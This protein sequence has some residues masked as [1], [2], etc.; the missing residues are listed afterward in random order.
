MGYD[1]TATLRLQYDK[2]KKNAEDASKVWTKVGNQMTT[3]GRDLTVALSAPIALI[4]KEMYKVGEEFDLAT[5]KLQ[6]LAG[7]GAEGLGRLTEQARKLGS[8]TI[9]TASEIV[10]L[11]LS[12]KRLGQTSDE[13]EQIT[14]TVLRLAQALDTDLADAGEF[15]VQTLNKMDESFLGFFDTASAAEFAAEGFAYAISNSALTID[16]LRASLNYVGSEANAAG[17]SF[18][19]T[20]SILAALADA[21]YTGSRAGTQLR[22]V[23]TELT[24]DG[25]DVSKEFFDIVKSGVSFEEALDAVGVRAAGVFAAL[26]GSSE[27]VKL[28]SEALQNSAGRLQYFADSMDE[29]LFASSKKVES[30]FGELSIAMTETLGPAIIAVNEFLARILRGFAAMPGPLKVAAAIIGG[31]LV[32]LPPLIFLYGSLTKAVAAATKNFTLLG[33]SIKTTFAAGGIA[34]IALTAIA[35]IMGGIKDESEKVNQIL[36]EVKTKINDIAKTG[37]R[38]A[39]VE[40][41]ILERDAAEAR[42]KLLRETEGE[43]TAIY[44]TQRAQ[45]DAIYKNLRDSAIENGNIITIQKEMTTTILPKFTDEQRQQIDNANKLANESYRQL[46]LTRSQTADEEE[47]VAKLNDQLAVNQDIVEAY[48]NRKEATAAEV[49][50]LSSLKD[51]YKRIQGEITRIQNIFQSQGGNLNQV[52]QDLKNYQ[53]LLN[54]VKN[55]IILLG[56]TVDEADDLLGSASIAKLIEQYITLSEKI[57]DIRSSKGVINLDNLNL[58]VEKLAELEKLLELVGV[59]LSLIE[60]T[61]A[62]NKAQQKLLEDNNEK[63]NDFKETMA[64]LVREVDQFGATGLDSELFA[65]ENRFKDLNEQFDLTPEQLEKV[66]EAFDILRQKT[67]EAASAAEE[68][69][70]KEQ[71]LEW[72]S[73]IVN[74]SN[75][76]VESLA[77]VANGTKT[78]SETIIEALGNVLKRVIALSI[79]W[80][81]LNV[82][83]GR[84]SAAANAA[85][86][87]QQFGTFLTSN[88]LGGLAPPTGGQNGGLRVSGVVSGSNLIIA[89]SRGVT[90]FDRTYG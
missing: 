53:D 70:F 50:T 18:S 4:G 56:G 67:I 48:Y 71:S 57:A 58:Q 36:E 29:S 69:L 61:D 45:Y 84:G 82:L 41:M 20:A 59:D 66:T 30:A 55:Q 22:R 25:R 88:L 52:T 10:E 76:F 89:N 63:A 65:L 49:T 74:L 54:D 32:S 90:A 17:L 19:D 62:F 43:Q 31:L 60:G 16:G 13:I 21:G 24:K 3:V 80:V 47:L 40:Q 6:G 77:N 34:T 46:E 68:E 5:K 11:Q 38:E 86:A 81:A 8:E 42:L 87:G 23:F 51:E 15:V 1:V 72:F 85:L 37:D 7:P 33:F 78:F 83:A 39:A 2:F 28:F 27:A 75:S 14:P 35:A 64:E 73:N 44:A 79:A 12:L 26:G 9:F